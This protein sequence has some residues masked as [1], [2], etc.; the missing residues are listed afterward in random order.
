MQ[1]QILQQLLAIVEKPSI[2]AY[3]RSESGD[4]LSQR[5][6]QKI[7]WAGGEHQEPAE[8]AEADFIVKHR[9]ALRSMVTHL[10]DDEEQEDEWVQASSQGQEFGRSSSGLSNPYMAFQM[11][12]ESESQEQ[13]KEE[14]AEEEEQ[15][16]LTPLPGMRTPFSSQ[17]YDALPQLGD[18]LSTPMH[19]DD[20]AEETL[21]MP[22]G[23]PLIGS[24]AEYKDLTSKEHQTHE[25]PIAESVETRDFRTPAPSRPRKPTPRDGHQIINDLRA[26]ERVA[27]ARNILP[28]NTAQLRPYLLGLLLVSSV[29]LAYLVSQKATGAGAGPATTLL[30][31]TPTLTSTPSEEATADTVAPEPVDIF[32]TPGDDETEEPSTADAPQATAGA[33]TPT[34]EDTRATASDTARA[35]TSTP[36]STTKQTKPAEKARVDKPAASSSRR[37]RSS[38]S[39]TKGKGSEKEKE[40]TKSKETEKE[41]APERLSL[42]HG[43]SNPSQ[44]SSKAAVP[45]L[46]GAWKGKV[47]GRSCYLNITSQNGERINAKISVEGED[48][49]EWKEFST[50]GRYNGTKKTFRLDAIDGSGALFRATV[51]ED[52]ELFGTAV[53]HAGGTKQV[54]TAFKK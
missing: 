32:G 14:H 35:A 44:P 47:K 24:V 34:A 31:E 21:I 42:L 29:P 11:L 13:A 54:W 22:E 9:A 39:S 45:K 50:A 46:T 37:S 16:P 43:G 40:P 15:D 23:S 4:S 20:L 5:L 17:D 30:V 18:D 33:A 10:T 25:I 8:K 2:Q 26:P 48:G 12:Q 53:L 49:G 1:P 28:Q 7:R 41:K 38:S 51:S 27:K 19:A 52:R 3:L 36:A 6:E